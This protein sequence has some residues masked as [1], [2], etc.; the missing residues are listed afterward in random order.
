M[1]VARFVAVFMLVIAIT[2]CGGGGGGGSNTNDSGS[3]AEPRQP[4]QTPDFW[5]RF[6]GSTDSVLPS[7][8]L[9]AG[10]YKITVYTSQYA[11]L[12]EVTTGGSS[13]LNVSAG[14]ASQGAEA[15]FQSSGGSYVFQLSNIG[16]SWA[17]TIEDID[18]NNPADITEI[19]NVYAVGPKVLGPYSVDTSAVYVFTMLCDSYFIMV[20]Y[21]PY[22][23][24]HG[25]YIFNESRGS[26]G[27]QAAVSFT[28][29]MVLFRTYNMDDQIWSVTAGVL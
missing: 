22:S 23:G 12:K 18:T 29:D 4:I 2:A 11:I 27:S 5:K 17:L 8:E 15:I 6:T 14:E 3:T 21:S 19:G 10:L 28:E 9:P 20:P 25:S 7:V 13:L 26:H 24:E 16:D 1:R